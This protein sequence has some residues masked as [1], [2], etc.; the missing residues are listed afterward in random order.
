MNSKE[1]RI[2]RSWIDTNVSES[3]VKEQVNRTDTVDYSFT[4]VAKVFK[5]IKRDYTL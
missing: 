5:R 2:L 1:K 4:K 3:Y